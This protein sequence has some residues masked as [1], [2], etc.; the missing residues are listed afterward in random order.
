M[1][2]IR[3]VDIGCF[4]DS[5]KRDVRLRFNRMSNSICVAYLIA[6]RERLVDA[7]T[8]R[9]MLVSLHNAR[10]EQGLEN[11]VDVYIYNCQFNFDRFAKSSYEDRCKLILE[12]LHAGLLKICVALDL[13]ADDFES[14]YEDVRVSRFVFKYRKGKPVVN[15]K[16]GLA[17]QLGIIST[18]ESMSVIAYVQQL[19]DEREVGIL[20]FVRSEEPD[21]RFE[22][23]H[24]GKLKWVSASRLSLT[25]NDSSLPPIEV[26]ISLA[27]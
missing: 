24:L 4:D 23:R 5:V 26:D 20:T 8:V 11:A 6:L 7:G 3:D 14:A 18:P 27:H 13:K 17:A 25:P 9:K 2:I 19:N 10:P 16:A 1:P 22:P 12:T 15:R 21:L